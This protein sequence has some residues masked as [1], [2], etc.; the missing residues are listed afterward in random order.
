MS[1]NYSIYS[2]PVY[3]LLALVPHVYAVRQVH[4]RFHHVESN[5]P[6][7]VSLMK[8]ANNQ[9]WNNVNP[10][11]VDTNETYKKAVGSEVFARFE[12]GEAAHKNMLENAPLLIGAVT[13]GNVVRLDACKLSFQ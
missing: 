6:P 4:D 8:S 12:R 2:I 7:Q 11:G 10:R 13:I 3:W 1:L 5:F 9:K